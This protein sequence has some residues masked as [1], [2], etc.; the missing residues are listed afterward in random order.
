MGLLR[1]ARSRRSIRRYSSE[2]IPLKDL[3]YILEIARH[4][5]SGANRQPWRFLVVGDKD[6]K[7]LIR[8]ECERA[9]KEF[10]ESASPELKQWLA[11]K[12]I[13]WRK[14]F[15]TEA[16]YLILVFGER[17]QPYWLES[18]WI[19]V[20]YM[21]LVAEELGYGT[22]TYTPSKVE[23]ANKLLGVPDNY[24][25]QVILPVGKPLEEKNPEERL[26]L[27]EICYLNRWGASFH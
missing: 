12:G 25:L 8:R 13:D 9:E 20:G 27:R 22:L 23:W 18:V 15:L 14:P 1:L 19:S 6:L 7:G 21:L 11:E 2:P 4:A 24:R 3:E 26:S 10:H 17:S 5:P 16:P